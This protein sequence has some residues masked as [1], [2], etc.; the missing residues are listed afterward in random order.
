MEILVKEKDIVV[1][2]ELLARGMESLPGF[3]TY[4]EGDNIIAKQVGLLSLSGR[5][6]RVIPLSGRYVPKKEDLI[7][8]K[9]VDVS[10]SGWR[11][12]I[13]WAFEAGLNMKDATSEF[14]EKKADLTQYYDFGDIISAQI[15]HVAGSKIIDLTTKGPGLRKLK[16]GR[17]IE[18]T[19]SKVPRVI[20]KQGSMITLIKEKTECKI[21]VGQNGRVWISGPTPEKEILAVDVINK[22]EHEAHLDGLTDRIKEYLEK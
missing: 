11:V 7:I 20:G 18:I 10:F 9:V 13:G 15:T 8:G 16:G 21:I 19:S 22:I 3:G 12:D 4:R 1:P 14:I 2:G 5:I 6:I 17:I